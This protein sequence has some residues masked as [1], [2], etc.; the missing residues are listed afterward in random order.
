MRVTVRRIIGSSYSI[1]LRG[2]KAGDCRQSKSDPSM[3]IS[4]QYGSR[5]AEETK[6]WPGR[7][8]VG[9]KIRGVSYKRFIDDLDG[10]HEPQGQ[11]LKRKAEL[12]RNSAM[13]AGR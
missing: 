7:G 1:K 11:E 10:E 12:N 4:G 3:K 8:K 2:Q 5:G 13:K 6:G 9:G